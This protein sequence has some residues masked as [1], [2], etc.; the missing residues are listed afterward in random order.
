MLARLDKVEGDWGQERVQMRA[1]LQEVADIRASTEKHCGKL[2]SKVAEI[3]FSLTC[4][5]SEMSGQ[6]VALKRLDAE[7]S[8]LFKAAQAN[9]AQQSYQRDQLV[10]SVLQINKHVT[11]T[12]PLPPT[13][14]QLARVIEM[15]EEQVIASPN[16]SMAI[17][18]EVAASIAELSYRL[19]T[20][21]S[22]NSDMFTLFTVVNANKSGVRMDA[23]VS[24]R[25]PLVLSESSGGAV[26]PTDDK[27]DMCVSFV[28]ETWQAMEAPKTDSFSIREEARKHIMRKFLLCLELSLSKLETI[29]VEAPS[30][31]SRT[32]STPSCLACDRPLKLK[33]AINIPGILSMKMKNSGSAT[34]RPAS[35]SASS[36][37]LQ[38]QQ[39]ARSQNISPIISNN[40]ENN[41]LKFDLANSQSILERMKYQLQSESVDMQVLASIPVAANASSVA[42][43]NFPSRPASAGASGHRMPKH[44]TTLLDV[45]SQN[46]T[47]M[48]KQQKISTSVKTADQQYVMRGGFKVRQGSSSQEQLVQS[49]TENYNRDISIPKSH[50]L[51]DYIQN[52]TEINHRQLLPSDK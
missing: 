11:A 45:N 29:V 43:S 41:A 36:M 12:S 7:V 9:T 8:D 40:D 35:A 2:D 39:Q 52:K 25:P 33:S 27:E 26:I 5:D 51:E 23:A 22:D 38:Q 17:S 42:T 1:M 46:L 31:L 32:P 3:A 16:F 15:F 6:D 50:L 19:A 49:L 20:C 37:H 48:P 44:K 14:T 28:R 24:E 13:P 21:F 18:G 10:D 47:F 4:V 30:S 34:G